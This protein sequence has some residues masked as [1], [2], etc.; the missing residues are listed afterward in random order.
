[1]A[2]FAEVGHGE[3]AA[4]DVIDADAA[5]AGPAVAVDEHDRDAAAGEPV[6]R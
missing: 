3:C 5:E 2:L 4:L 1:M 6:E